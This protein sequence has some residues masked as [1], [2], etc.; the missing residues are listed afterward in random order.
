MRRT[1]QSNKLEFTSPDR[2]VF[3][4]TGYT[5][6]DVL[7][8]YNQVSD[9]LLPHLRARPI[10]IERFPKGVKEG[11]QHF[12]QKNTPAYYPAWV[13]RAKLPTEKGKTI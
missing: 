12:W 8:Y 9:F 3:P 4:A 2:I 1:R 13:P 10:T 11:A 5:K 6:G 7:D